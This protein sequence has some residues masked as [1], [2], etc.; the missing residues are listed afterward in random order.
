MQKI[1]LGPAG[2]P[3]KS[4]LEGITEVKKLGL[5]AMEVQYTH[6]I[7]MN[8]ALAEEVGKVA[9]KEKIS[10]SIHAPYYIN[11]LSSD[12][13]ILEA[14]RKRILDSCHRGHLMKATKVVF[15]PGYYGKKS[16]EESYKIMKEE[17]KIIQKEIRKK[18][19]KIDIAPETMGRTFQIGQGIEMQFLR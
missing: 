9:E 13:K 18:R 7:K 5:Q 11:L 1:L 19:W 10:L 16:K 3:A 4:T 12:P 15:H 8:L 17:L 6:G 2:S 14:S